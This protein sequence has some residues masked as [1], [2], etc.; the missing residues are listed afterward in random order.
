MFNQ[1][2]T[3][4]DGGQYDLSEQLFRNI[5]TSSESSNLEQNNDSTVV[6]KNEEYDDICAYSLFFLAM[7]EY[8][9]SNMYNSGKL[10]ERVLEYPNW[11]KVDNVLIWLA[12]ICFRQDKY[13]DALEYLGKV[14]DK[15]L[16]NYKKNMKDKYITPYISSNA[17]NSCILRYP[18]DKFIFN[19]WIKKQKHADIVERRPWI[20][21]WLEECGYVKTKRNTLKFQKKDTYNVAVFLPLNSENIDSASAK[22]FDLY[23]G[24]EYALE[25]SEYKN[26]NVKLYDT[27]L[28]QWSL[29]KILQLEEMKNVDFIVGIFGNSLNV[30]SDFS[31]KNKINMIEIESS[32][33]SHLGKNRYGYLMQSSGITQAHYAAMSLIKHFRISHE[34]NIVVVSS[35]SKDDIEQVDAFKSTLLLHEYSNVVDVILDSKRNKEIVFYA[36]EQQKN[37]QKLKENKKGEDSDIVLVETTEQDEIIK[38]INNA[39]H[40]YVATNNALVLTNLISLLQTDRTNNPLMFCSHDFLET[41]DINSLL[42]QNIYFLTSS[43]IDYSLENVKVFINTFHEKF[44]HYPNKLAFYG[45]DLMNFVIKQLNDFGRY[46]QCSKDGYKCDCTF[47]PG[48]NYGCYHDNQNVLMIRYDGYNPTVVVKSI[49]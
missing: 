17:A 5:V 44:K 32:Q 24:I 7:I 35:T 20:V 28:P 22:Y 8:K 23:K 46:P 11:N 36:R 15:S 10:F 13:V 25:Q 30:I 42:N 2:K 45:F 16:E 9:K 14:K 39:T 38:H 31:K 3:Y 27:Q 49:N 1:A 4:F 29:R 21:S 48:I 41:V 47:L 6:N 19:N 34:D 37:K 33:L 40:V 12:D 18:N 43:F 26:I